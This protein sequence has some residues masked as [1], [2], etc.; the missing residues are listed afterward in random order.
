[1]YDQW[2]GDECEKNKMNDHNIVIFFYGLRWMAGLKYSKRS[3]NISS[4]LKEKK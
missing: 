1:M 2:R 3:K 4:G